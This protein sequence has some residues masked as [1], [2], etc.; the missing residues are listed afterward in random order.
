MKNIKKKIKWIVIILFILGLSGVGTLAGIF[1]HYS[2]G[3]YGEKELKNFNPETALSIYDRNDKLIAIFYKR[4]GRKTIIPHNKIPKFIINTF[5]SVEDKRFFEHSGLDYKGIFRAIVIDILTMSKK[6]GAS[7]ITQQ[8]AKNLLLSNAKH[9]SRKIKEMILAKRIEE[10]LTKEEIIALYL[11]NIYFGNSN[12]GIAEGARFYFN[13]SLEDLDIGEVAYLAGVPKN[14]AGYRLNRHPLKAKKRQQ[15]VL[16]RMLNAKV[17]TQKQFDEFYDKELEFIGGSKKY[18][19]TASY[20]SRHIMKILKSKYDDDFLYHKSLKIKT[21]LDVSLQK[22]AILALR[23]GL[24]NLNKRQG[25]LKPLRYYEEEKDSLNKLNYI[26]PLVEEGVVIKIDNKNGWAKLKTKDKVVIVIKKDL[27][28]VRKFN[29]SLNYSPRINNLEKILKLDYIYAVKPKIGFMVIIENEKE[30][31]YPLYEIYP[32]PKVQG[33]IVSIDVETREVISLVGGYS[34]KLSPFNRATQALRQ[35]GSVFKPFVYAATIKFLKDE[36]GDDDIGY[37]DYT[38]SKIVFDTPEPIINRK[39][40]AVW[41]PMNFVKMK[42]RN[43][44]SLK[45]ALSKSVNMVSV[46][47]FSKLIDNFSKISEDKYDVEKGFDKFFKWL[48]DFGLD[49]RN[50]RKTYQMALGNVEIRLI[51]LVSAYT[52]FP[53][54]GLYQKPKFILSIKDINNKEYY[55]NENKQNRIMT[56]GEAY[57]MVNMM[58][59]VVNHGTAVR[60]KKLKRPVGGKTGTTNAQRNACFIG[61]TKDLVTGVWVGFD[62]RIPMGKFVQGGRTA[63]PIWLYYMEKALKDKPVL[64]FEAPEDIVFEYVDKDTGKLTSKESK[65]ALLS[66]FIKGRLPE[67]VKDKNFIDSNTYIMEEDSD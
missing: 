60:A 21:T 14:P 67:K 15:T 55:E 50:I 30:V 8:V 66:P 38:P 11:N 41:K 9:F 7:T 12:Y 28:W 33:A 56:T 1:Y 25:I 19:G 6:E 43:E 53:S 26:A 61:Y 27:S 42:F 64:E 54:Y 36:N 45:T 37:H 59:E 40:G 17:I 46:K 24:R 13:K 16:R 2:Q 4:D 52:A 23:K 18:F 31:D 3:L 63:A 44:L 47:L 10:M 58:Q 35:V 62:N 34:Y 65:N 57:L 5:V 48:Q 22:S 32:V 29:P 39:T 51:D 20:F 49:T